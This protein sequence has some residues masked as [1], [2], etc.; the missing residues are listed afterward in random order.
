M[1]SPYIVRASRDGDQFHYLW[2]A[3]RCLAL[4]QP[5]PTLVSIAIE[6]PSPN[7]QSAGSPPLAGE[8]AIDIAEYEGSE[9]LESAAT[10]RYLQLK[11][12]T[13]C[14]HQAW[15]ASRM[16][17]TVTAFAGRYR[18]LVE[19]LGA[20]DV[21]RRFEFWFVTNR[22][23]N[24]TVRQAV[25]HATAGLSYCSSEEIHRLRYLTG[26]A[27]PQ[28]A[29]FCGCLRLEDGQAGFLDQRNSLIEEVGAFLPDSENEALLPLK[30]L[31]SSRATTEFAHCPTI[32]R[33]D[34]LGALHTDQ[35]RLYPAPCLID[36]IENAI[37]REQDP[38][39]VSSIISAG[40]RPV[41]VHALSGV[42]KS[43]FASQLPG[44]LPA[45]SAAVVYDCFGNGGYRTSAHPRHRNRDALVQIANEL[46][47]RGLCNLLIPSSYADR[48]SYMRAFVSAGGKSL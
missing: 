8:C 30:E 33:T 45:G 42:G 12:S 38:E 4:L 43:I 20:D 31:V 28:I 10:V 46:A 44:A 47:C 17:P 18:D 6:G 19:R 11:H 29:K 21:R 2:A 22:P 5:N 13:V 48:S 23:V 27:K 24:N 39:L 36:S 9:E 40:A 34:V 25:A 37:P 7:E 3:R 41:I 14:P 15:T 16:K 1:S 35:D 32:N 26:L